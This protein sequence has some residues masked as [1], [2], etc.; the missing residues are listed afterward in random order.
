[1]SSF[2]L[3]LSKGAIIHEMMMMIALNSICSAAIDF[4]SSLTF[5][6]HE[7]F[8]LGRQKVF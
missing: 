2:G 4:D 5:L 1:M 6:A 8:V 7:C 3:K